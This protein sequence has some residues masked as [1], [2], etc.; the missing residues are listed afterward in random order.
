V[1]TDGWV[2][3]EEA[4]KYKSQLA[5]ELDPDIIFCVEQKDE[6]AP[7]LVA[8]EQFRKTMIDSPLTAKQR[9][10]EKRR[11]LRELGYIK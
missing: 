6:L 5:E 8:L 3:G 4:V 2:E 1:N 7:L 11:N 10:R 9:S